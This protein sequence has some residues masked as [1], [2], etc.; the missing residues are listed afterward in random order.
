[1]TTTRPQKID[2][3]QVRLFL[4]DAQKKAMAARKNLEIDE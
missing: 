1:M 2:I 3:K 4:S